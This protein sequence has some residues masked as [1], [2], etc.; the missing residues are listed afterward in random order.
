MGR[1]AKFG[2]VEAPI[3]L[4]LGLVWKL[5]LDRA[6][7][8]AALLA[9]A[10][11]VGALLALVGQTY[12]TGAD[13]FEL[14]FA[15]ALAILPWALVARFAALWI[16]WLGL[17]N[18]AVSLYFSTFGGWLGLMFGTEEQ[19]WLH[20]ALNT[21]GLVV[22]EVLAASGADWLRE[23]WAVRILATASGVCVT[24][25]ALIAVVDS[26]TRAGA[27]LL[28]W[29]AWLAAAYAVYRHLLQDVFVLAGGTLS[30][31]VVVAAFLGMHM[32][33]GEGGGFLL[34]GMIVIALSA[35]GGYWLR[36]VVVAGESR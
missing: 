18:L 34:I 20:F 36:S 11:L 22:W 15:W 3:L 7:G 8:K 6:T 27:S 17:A 5:G 16:L 14:F 33:D 30:V 29:A 9:A 10:I 4:A 12:Q 28:A 24:M 1:F 31:I 21:F 2:L 25:L 32:I 35:A 19:L 23:R 13:T 26:G